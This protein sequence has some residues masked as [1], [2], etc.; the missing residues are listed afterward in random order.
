MEKKRRSYRRGKVVR[1]HKRLTAEQRAQFARERRALV[2]KLI[3][4]HGF[5]GALVVEHI[6]G[7]QYLVRLADGSEVFASHKKP[8]QKPGSEAITDQDGSWALWETR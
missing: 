8:Q 1:N 5:E 3:L 7:S 6:R 2:G 4:Q